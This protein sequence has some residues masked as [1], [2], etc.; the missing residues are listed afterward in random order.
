MP[1]TPLIALVSAATVM[2]ML[3]FLGANMALAGLR[4]RMPV[5]TPRLRTVAV[6]L[7][8]IGASVETV[9]TVRTA[10]TWPWTE[11]DQHGY[12]L[13]Q[14]AGYELFQAANESQAIG[15]APVYQLG[16][17]N[18]VYFYKGL[19]VGDWFG[20]ARY[21]AMFTHDAASGQDLLDPAAARE[22]LDRFS[23]KAV[24]IN[25]QRFGHYDK[26]RWSQD[27]ELIKASDN[28]SLWLLRHQL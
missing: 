10:Q 17:E 13:T 12:Y 4:D 9:A 15:G 16:F 23:A 3:R 7:A 6:T 28:G 11:H 1:I 26:N 19:V 25:E 20:I 24:L 14:V 8:V 18:L 22:V 21:R 27:F 5:L 2:R